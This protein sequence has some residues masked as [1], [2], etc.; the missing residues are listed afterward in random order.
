V[1]DRVKGTKVMEGIVGFII[2]ETK[3]FDIEGNGIRFIFK[4]L[5][6]RLLCG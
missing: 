3:V 4:L 1:R 2:E 6:F 5:G